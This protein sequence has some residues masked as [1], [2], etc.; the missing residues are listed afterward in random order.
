M[1]P[2][3]ATNG[4]LSFKSRPCTFHNNGM[5]AVKKGCCVTTVPRLKQ[6]R[7]RLV[8]Y[9]PWSWKVLFEKTMTKPITFLCPHS[10]SKEKA[11]RTMILVLVFDSS[12]TA[13]HVQSSQSL[14]DIACS[15]NAQFQLFMDLILVCKEIKTA[16]VVSADTPKTR[17]CLIWS[18]I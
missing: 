15:K 7:P 16:N 17:S 14:Q 5:F 1:L 4:L 10:V 3:Y 8:I 12:G 9:S 13:L 11:G 18:L 2:V 6:F